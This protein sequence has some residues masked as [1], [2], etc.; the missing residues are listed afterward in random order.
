MPLIQSRTTSDIIL[1]VC[2]AYCLSVSSSLSESRT[3]NVFSLGI[4]ADIVLLYTSSLAQAK[5]REYRQSNNRY[6]SRQV[7]L[8]HEARV[9]RLN[10]AWT[11]TSADTAKSARLAG[12]HK[13]RKMYGRAYRN[14]ERNL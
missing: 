13:T 11:Q 7:M 8:V 2:S 14:V 1:S 4:V 9:T 12:C 6:L 10:N 3:L 5:I